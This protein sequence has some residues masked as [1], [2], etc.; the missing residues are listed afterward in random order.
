[1]FVLNYWLRE[2]LLSTIANRF[3]MR[4]ESKQLMLLCAKSALVSDTSFYDIKNTL[5]AVM[6]NHMKCSSINS[7]GS[8]VVVA[9]KQRLKSK[10]FCKEK[11]G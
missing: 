4:C 11:A 7:V 8:R 1:M 5:S 10:N 6:A 3:E 9:Q 2:F